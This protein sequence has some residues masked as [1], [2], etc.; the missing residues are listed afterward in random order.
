VREGK[1]NNS[2]FQ[3]R[4]LGTGPRADIIRQRFLLACQRVGII[5]GHRP[6]NLDCSRFL[7]P[8]IDKKQMTLF[9]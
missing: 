2:D 8:K 7:P 4:M 1:L 3:T 9:D 6:V 5:A